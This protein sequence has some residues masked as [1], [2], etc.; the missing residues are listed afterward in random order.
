MPNWKGQ[1]QV[2]GK[3]KG[4]KEGGR[5]AACRHAST[6]PLSVN[7][8]HVDTGRLPK[9]TGRNALP[10][11]NPIQSSL[12]SC[13]HGRAVRRRELVQRVFRQT[14]LSPALRP[15]LL[16]LPLCWPRATLIPR[17]RWLHTT[18]CLVS[19][20]CRT[21]ARRLQPQLLQ[22]C[23]RCPLTAPCLSC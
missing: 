19:T 7:L 15:S 20:C 10:Q 17:L 12:A 14:R 23:A 2:Q 22:H 18:C 8:S 1:K 11:Y 9:C 5:G 3:G 16:P 13:P 21:S 4:V 6:C